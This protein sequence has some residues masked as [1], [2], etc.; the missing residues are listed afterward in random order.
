MYKPWTHLSMFALGVG[1]GF[2]C[3]NKNKLAKISKHT[4]SKLSNGF[5][6]SVSK[7]EQ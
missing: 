3:R 5:M 1:T 2:Y 6:G 7:L 4:G